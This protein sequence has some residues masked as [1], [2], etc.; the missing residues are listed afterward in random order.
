MA[1]RGLKDC[2]LTTA[3]EACGKTR[4]RQRHRETW[5]WNA[6]VAD[7][8]AE[9]RRLFKIYK[10]SATGSDQRKIEEDKRRYDVAKRVAKR[11]V[12]KA[13]EVERRKF[14]E[15]LDESDDKGTIFRVAK[16]IVRSNRDVVGGTCVK[17]AHGKIVVDEQKVLDRWREY[18]EKLSNEEF[19]WN[20]DTLT[21]AD[22]T[23]GPS[24][25]ITVE[26][27]QAAIKR[28]KRNKAA[29]PSGVVA[30]M[31]KAAG[32]AGALWVTDVCNSVVSQGKISEDWCNSW[33]VNVY[34]GKGDALEC[35]SY[36]GIR[37]LE[38]VSM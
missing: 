37:L 3:E 21:T 18:Y 4:G 24:E 33:M 12:S 17:D 14:G 26:E 9:K 10:K 28:M 8:V 5:W 34:K 11:V 23:I 31:L 16:Q 32:K 6:E 20:R 36:R 7:S 13:Q 30:D 2:L 1:W 19:P 27:V 29:G 25:K 15:M 35:G 38:H 22:A